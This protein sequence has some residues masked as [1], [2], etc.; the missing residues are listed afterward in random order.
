MIS[1]ILH[2]IAAPFSNYYDLTI[3]EP[4]REVS[5]AAKSKAHNFLVEHEAKRHFSFLNYIRKQRV[6][7]SPENTD[8]KEEL[9]ELSNLR[10]RYIRDTHIS[11]DSQSWLH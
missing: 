3:A 6:M 7:V 9:T 1:K 8:N 5:C 4:C 11:V 10:E 2:L